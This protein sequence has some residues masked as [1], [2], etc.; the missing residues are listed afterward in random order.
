MRFDRTVLAPLLAVL[1]LAAPAIAPA[2]ESDV[3]RLL[4]LLDA[5]A[6]QDLAQAVEE[7]PEDAVLRERYGFALLEDGRDAE[8]AAQFTRAWQLDWNRWRA[9]MGLGAAAA[10]QGDVDSARLWFDTALTLQPRSAELLTR[11]AELHLQVGEIEEGI[12]QA[13]AALELVDSS[14]TRLLLANLL[15]RSRAG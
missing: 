11:S 4:R 10:R 13:R 7:S 9:V 3:E 14:E 1:A 15:A 6:S 12:A 2:A 8:A 5:G